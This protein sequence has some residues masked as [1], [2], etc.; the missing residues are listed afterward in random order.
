MC[1]KR[2]CALGHV[3]NHK[4]VYRAYCALRLNQARRTKKRVLT[5]VRVAQDV[6]TVLNDLCAMDFM[7][8]ALYDGR[9]YRAFNVLDE[10]NS[11]CFAI[12]VAMSL[13]SVRLTHVL[14][15][16]TTLHGT[17]LRFRGDNGPEFITGILRD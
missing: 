8:D 13:P 4:R 10:R 7:R 16:L 1:G 11:K 17:P 2:L 3:W 9:K 12:E 15:Q 5:R 6:A 14:D